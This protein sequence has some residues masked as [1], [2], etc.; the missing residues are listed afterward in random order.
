MTEQIPSLFIEHSCK[1]MR[2]MTEL[3]DNSLA[4]LTD[5]QIWAR[6]SDAENAIGNLILHLC[7][8]MRQWIGAAVGGLSDIRVRDAEFAARDGMNRVELKALFH[9]QV[10]ACLAII[11]KLTPERL[12]ETVRP[13]GQEVSVLQAVYQVVGH[14]QQHAGQIVF[15]TKMLTG[16]M[17]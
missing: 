15:A 14:L 1:K 9:A 16:P 4:K 6:G 11:G 7:G 12:V 17:T 3:I 10:E 8:N 13:Q 2:Q 5:E